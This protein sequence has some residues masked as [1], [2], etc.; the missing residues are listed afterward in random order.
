MIELILIKLFLYRNIYT[1]YR[2]YITPYK[3]QEML[4][5]LLDKMHEDL[6]RDIAFSEFK[7]VV[8]QQDIN[9]KETIE[10]I[11][12]EEVGIDVA[13]N[14]VMSYIEMKWAHELALKAILVSEGSES[15]ETLRQTYDSLNDLQGKDD[16]KYLLTND[17]EQ[18]Y[19][20]VDRKGGIQWRL[21]WLNEHLGGLHKGD[22]GFVFAR[23]NVGKSTFVASEISYM[24]KQIDTP[25]CFF[26]NEEAGARMKWRIFQAYF[27]ATEQ[28][29]KDNIKKCQEKFLEET[30]G[31]FHFF[32]MPVIHKR[33]VEAICKDIKPGLIVI[34][35]IDKIE[36][37]KGDREDLRLGKIYTWARE[38]AKQYA[39][40]IAVCQAGASAENKKWL[41]HNDINLA[42]TAKGSEADFILGIG[43]T[44][45]V[46]YEYV[47]YLHFVKNK[48]KHGVHKHECLID[49]DV[50]RYKSM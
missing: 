44:F 24:L 45:D 49:P 20:E 13:E 18:L 39:P 4:F 34:D 31:L 10:S 14:V 50:A 2:R 47:R 16:S 21:P 42:H 36:G 3:E 6:Q 19:N 11:E 41:T 5:S 32:D 29:L 22:F 23:T 25:T 40:V 33:E 48:F 17:F 1:K 26:F 9:L 35:N 46:G 30:K 37:F 38:Q 27:G 8:L 12:K 7:L 15:V 28:R 43:A